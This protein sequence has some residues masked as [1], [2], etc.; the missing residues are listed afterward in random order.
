MMQVRV[1]RKNFPFLTFVQAESLFEALKENFKNFTFKGIALVSQ[2]NRNTSLSGRV[3]FGEGPRISPFVL[4]DE[5]QN[6]PLAL[7]YATRRDPR[8]SHYSF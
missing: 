6:I 4:D 3:V 1:S 5:Y 2:A 7:I 8:F